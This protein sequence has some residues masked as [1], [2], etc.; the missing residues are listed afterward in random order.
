MPDSQHLAFLPCLCLEEPG[1]GDVDWS[2]ASDEVLFNNGRDR[3]RIVNENELVQV[4]GNT[5]MRKKK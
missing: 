2:L 5:P 3:F 4:I 1:G